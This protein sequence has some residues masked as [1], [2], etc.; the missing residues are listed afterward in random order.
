M[1]R[2]VIQ[3]KAARDVCLQSAVWALM[4]G[5]PCWGRCDRKAGLKPAMG[6]LMVRLADLNGAG[7]R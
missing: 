3:L 6:A 5:W 7:H 1:C 4:S 2:A